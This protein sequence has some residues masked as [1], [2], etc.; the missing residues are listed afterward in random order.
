[1]ADSWEVQAGGV[2]L[3]NWVDHQ[4]GQGSLQGAQASRAVASADK[5]YP[6]NIWNPRPLGASRTCRGRQDTA[7]RI[8][9]ARHVQAL[10]QLIKSADAYIVVRTRRTSWFPSG[11]YP[12]P[13]AALED[14]V[15]AVLTPGRMPIGGMPYWGGIP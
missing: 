9:L 1:M 14:E 8:C 3:G 7:A 13:E 15:D 6:L 11:A 2:L 4:V 12:H 10:A 5:L